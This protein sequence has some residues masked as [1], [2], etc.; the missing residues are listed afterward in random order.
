MYIQDLNLVKVFVGA[1]I[2]FV[3]GS[4]WY[5][6]LLFA[7][8]WMKLVGLTKEKIGANKGN[9]G[10][11]MGGTFLSNL[12]LSFVLSRFVD[13][14][15]YTSFIEGVMMGFWIWL[16]FVATTMVP[17]YLYLRKST[18]LFLITSG[19]HLVSLLVLGGLMAAWW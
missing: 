5:S 11:M 2:Y 16:G 18:K 17:D 7:N 14:A 6:P 1:M 4:L 8:A 19:Y 10:V 9:M 3:I 15:G 13:M 12:V